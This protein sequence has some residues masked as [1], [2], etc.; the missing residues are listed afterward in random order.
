MGLH[1]RKYGNILSPSSI[2]KSPSHLVE[3]FTSKGNLDWLNAEEN[4]ITTTPLKQA[5]KF[6]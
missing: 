3:I 2:F 1:Y 4:F 6:A 5:L